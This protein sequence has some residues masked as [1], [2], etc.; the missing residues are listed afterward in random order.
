MTGRKGKI[1]IVDDE[2]ESSIMGA[3][4]RRMEDE[5]WD[6]IV[7]EPEG[8]GLLA[9]EFESAALYALEVER[10]DGVL[11]DVRFG[12][13]PYDRFKGLGILRKIVERH[14]GLPILMFTQYAQGPEREMAVRGSLKWDASIDFVDKL[15]GPE[16]VV[17]RM[18]RLIGTAPDVIPIGPSIRLDTKSRTVY[19]G[20]GDRSKPVHEIRGVKFEILRELATT[21]YRSPGQLVAF[22]KLERLSEGQDPR[23]VLRV[24]IREIKDALGGAMGLHFGAQDLIVNV[25]DEGY[26]LV[27]PKS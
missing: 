2:W 21:W 9:E 14:P 23:R 5:G 15:A 18:R 10:P 26:R 8:Q 13:H 17:L 19:V 1:L 12:E 16:E 11:L 4:R 27:P 3:V 25:R 24:R 20:S 7:V 22:T 6:S